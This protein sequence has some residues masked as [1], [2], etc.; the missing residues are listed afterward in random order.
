VSA[1]LAGRWLWFC[2][3]L[4]VA[5]LLLGVLWLRRQAAGTWTYDSW[6]TLTKLMDTL[7]LV[8]LVVLLIGAV[9]FI[10]WFQRSYTNLAAL[11]GP[12][13]DQQWSRR[14]VAVCAQRAIAVVGGTSRRQ[15][16]RAQTLGLVAEGAR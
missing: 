9:I 4:A 8:Q 5:G 12:V 6:T 15:K 1:L 2:F 13:P 7:A 14:V 3:A 16:A 10:V 11:V